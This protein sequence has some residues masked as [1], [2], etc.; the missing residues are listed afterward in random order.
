M[1]PSR[2]Q[3]LQTLGVAVA[4]IAGCLS[5]PADTA[6]TALSPGETHEADDG[7]TISV[8][9]PAVHQSVVT[10]E[11]VSGTH[12]YERVADAGTGQYVAF[13]ATT[14]GFDLGEDGRE[15][16]GEPI[17]VPL[18]IEL[19][20]T[21]HADPIPVGRDGRAARD[22]VAVRVP[23]EDITDAAVVWAREDDP[24]P[25]WEL[26]SALT[27]RL[28]ATP[29]FEVKSWSV[30]DSV[31][32]GQRFEASITVGN[33]GDRDG[34]FLATLGVKQGSLGVPETSVEVPAGETRTHTVSVEPHYSESIE[35]LR[36]VVD[37]GVGRETKSVAVERSGTTTT[38][39]SGE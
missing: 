19:D 8:N 37:W 2:R 7:R 34:R 38:S 18:A 6:D 13:V 4:G 23:V 3:T 29:E 15:Q 1:P 27:D 21:R 39:E 33:A 10:V 36:V 17:D 32:Y 20:G 26:G 22:H 16:Y 30:P 12:Y 31:P 25:R 35:S 11:H 24:Q 5:A 28:A 14:T 9:D